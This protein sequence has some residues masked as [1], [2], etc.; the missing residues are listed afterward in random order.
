MA[1]AK[2]SGEPKKSKRGGARPGSGRPRTNALKNTIS[3]VLISE[4]E[5]LS[6]EELMPAIRELVAGVQVQQYDKKGNARIYQQ[7]PSAQ[8]AIYVMDRML[9]K[10]PNRTEITGGT[11]DNGNERPIPIKLLGP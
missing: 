5:S 2:T 1:K 9:G 8:M 4:L 6:R 7:P 3:N 11:D 10:L